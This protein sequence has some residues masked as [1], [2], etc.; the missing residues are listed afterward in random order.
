M[1][2]VLG[3]LLGWLVS[4]SCQAIIAMALAGTAFAFGPGHNIP[5]FVG[6]GITEA[7][8]MLTIMAVVIVVSGLSL[9]IVA[10]WLENR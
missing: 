1:A 7:G 4:H 6:I 8:K 2:G 10:Y 3:V 5:S 9:G